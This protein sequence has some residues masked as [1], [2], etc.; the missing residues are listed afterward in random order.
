MQKSFSTLQ[1][2]QE[3]FSWK[4]LAVV[5]LPCFESGQRGC[6]ENSSGRGCGQRRVVVEVEK[7]KDARRV[8]TTPLHPK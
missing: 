4:E 5:T 2:E 1:S 3:G 6:I 8:F 7:G